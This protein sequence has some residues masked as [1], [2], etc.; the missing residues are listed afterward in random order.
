VIKTAAVIVPPLCDFYFTRHRFSALGANIVGQLLERAGIRAT[1]LNFPLLNVKGT[2]IDL[3]PEIFYLK[4]FLIDGETGRLSFFTRYRR[5]GPA[6]DRCAGM[7]EAL[8]PDLCFFSLFAFCYGDDVRTLAAH[9]KAKLPTIPLIIGGAGASSYPEYQLTRAFD[10][11]LQGEAEACLPPFLDAIQRSGSDFSGVKG[12][13]RNTVQSAVYPKT[14]PA[15]AMDVP[16]M[17]EMLIPLLKTSESS[18]T[19]TYAT[20]LARGCPKRCDFCS[21][22]LLFGK[23]LRT[24]SLQRL[25]DLLQSRLSEIVRPGKR[26]IINIED[27]NLLCDEALFKAVIAIFRT[28]IPDAGF[29]AENGLDYTLLTPQLCTWLIENGMRKF[30]LS[31]ASTNTAILQNRGRSLDLGRYE[32]VIALLAAKNIPTVTYFMCGFKEDTVQTVADALNYLNDKPTRIGISPFYPVP[33]L[34]GFTDPRKFTPLT[35]R[36]CCGSSMYSWN[37]SLSTA[38]MVTAFRLARLSNLKKSP[39]KSVMEEKVLSLI[40]KEKRLYTVKLGIN[41]NEEITP[42]SGMDGELLERVNFL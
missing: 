38:T 9:I 21:S 22:R 14:Q 12:S 1:V 25:D 27:D 2:P 42:V 23:T 4:P 32:M 18:R 19:V 6:N 30:N 3:P 33:G 41:G 20:S 40:R 8:R 34:P 17:D 35:A 28:H 13:Y 24:V 26:T 37:Q 31:L 10:H 15:G 39:I 11:L 16:H 29:I 36:L 5:F 7:I